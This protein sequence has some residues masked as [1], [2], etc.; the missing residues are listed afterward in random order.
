MDSLTIVYLLERFNR[1]SDKCKKIGNDLK[2][3][4]SYI[5]LQ[6]DGSGRIVIVGEKILPTFEERVID[7]IFSDPEDTTS[8]IIFE[9][10]AELL[11]IIG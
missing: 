5:E 10:P 1:W 2:V 4:N 7:S 11:A 8:E 6:S 9:S 3:V